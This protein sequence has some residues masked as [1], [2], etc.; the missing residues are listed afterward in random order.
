M[1]ILSFEAVRRCGN[2]VDLEKCCKMRIW[3]QKS[4]SIQPRTSLPKFDKPACCLPHPKGSAKQ[5]CARA[6]G[7]HDELVR[8]C[9][10]I[11][12]YDHPTL[13][14]KCTCEILEERAHELC[15][16]I[17]FDQE[18]ADIFCRMMAP[19]KTISVSRSPNGRSR[20]IVDR[21]S[22]CH[23]CCILNAPS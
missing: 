13:K 7:K 14:A 11:T 1:Q 4:A 20:E 12:R 10:A 2:L 19:T 23:S 6:V 15:I 21:G 8:H 3:L 22:A 5:P 17:D 16:T 18:L 9:H